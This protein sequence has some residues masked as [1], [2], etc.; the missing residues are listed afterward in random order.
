MHYSAS[1]NLYTRIDLWLVARSLLGYLCPEA[2]WPRTYSDHSLV[3]LT[4]T[5]DALSIPPFSWRFLLYSL[6]DSIF[7]DELATAIKD[8]FQIN[9]GSLASVGVVWE[10][11][12]FYIWG[13]PI[14]KHAGVL[15][16]NRG[17]LQ[18]LER[19]LAQLKWD[20]QTS[21]D[22]QTLGHI[23]AKVREFHDTAQEEIQH[24]G[25][26]TTARA[27]GDGER[28][29]SVLANLIHPNREKSA[30][31]A[32]KAEDGTA[33]RDPECIVYRICEYYQSLY[34]SRV[35]LGQEAILDSLTHI[36]MPRLTDPER[37]SLGAPLTLEKIDS[38]LVGIADDKALGPDGLTVRFYKTYKNLLLPQLKE[39]FEEMVE[40][41]LMPHR[42][43]KRC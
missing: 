27:Y 26:Y 22:N 37:E 31:I 32:V 9:K 25:K 21:A 3:P 11:F 38:A 24:L 18:L 4:M 14:A 10:T 13:I 43:G 12:K 8:F 36:T 35:I 29:G 19:D 1:H 28:P 5:L 42:C 39:V 17:H 40:R 6:L 15:K 7:R 34:T 33:L 20:H 30:I 16:S 41:G 23:H 2:P